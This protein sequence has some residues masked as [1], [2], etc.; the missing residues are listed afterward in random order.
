LD[1]THP[2]AGLPFHAGLSIRKIAPDVFECRLDL[3]MRL[4]FLAGKGVLTFDFAGHHEAVRNYLRG[5]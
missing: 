3:K 1:T 4:V 5:R 2:W